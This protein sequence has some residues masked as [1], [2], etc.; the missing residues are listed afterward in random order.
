MKAGP[1]CILKDVFALRFADIQLILNSGFFSY[2][3][4]T[5]TNIQVFAPV[6]RLQ[7]TTVWRS[8][9]VKLN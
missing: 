5:R 4:I 6:H 3:E 9:S 2:C 1:A 7:V 8:Y